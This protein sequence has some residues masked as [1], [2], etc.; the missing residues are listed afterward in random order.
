MYFLRRS[1]FSFAKRFMPQHV[2]WAAALTLRC[3]LFL[4]RKLGQCWAERPS[5]SPSGWLPFTGAVLA[6]VGSNVS[7]SLNLALIAAT[8]PHAIN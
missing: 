5:H 4:S 8:K 2:L 3:C 7:E 6:R 1:R